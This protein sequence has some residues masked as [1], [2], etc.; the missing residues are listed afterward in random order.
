MKSIFVKMVTALSSVFE[1]IARRG[2]K[3]PDT[4]SHTVDTPPTS[5]IPDE[6]EEPPTRE[7]DE[8]MTALSYMKQYM[9]AQ[10]TGSEMPPGDLSVLITDKEREAMEHT[11]FGMLNEML[12]LVTGMDEEEPE[13]PED[14]L[15]IIRLTRKQIEILDGAHKKL[16]FALFHSDAEDLSDV[17]ESA[18]SE[19][20]FNLFIGDFPQA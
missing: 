10:L 11:P 3:R 12:G 16:L 9:G 14:P 2:G 20:D 15:N 1:R 13:K 5:D 17:Y 7:V 18:C 8:Q 4:V 6:T 19:E